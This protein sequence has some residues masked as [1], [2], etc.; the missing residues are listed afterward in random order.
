MEDPTV[1]QAKRFG[2]VSCS[3]GTPLLV[4]ARLMSEEDI[5]ALVVLDDDQ[6]LAG[7]ISRMDLLRAKTECADWRNEPVE[8]WMSRQVITVSPRD[9]LSHVADL[10]LHKGIHRVVAVQEDRGKKHPIAVISAADLV[11]HMAKEKT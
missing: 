10:L 8:S 7:I 3:C 4:A 1:I 6:Q 11:Y 5:S 9:H 2:I